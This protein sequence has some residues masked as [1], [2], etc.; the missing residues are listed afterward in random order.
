MTNL[1]CLRPVLKTSLQWALECFRNKVKGVLTINIDCSLNECV[2]TL[3]T[4]WKTE[5]E[6]QT[7]TYTHIHSERDK[8][9]ADREMERERDRELKGDG[10][11]WP[12]ISTSLMKYTYA[13]NFQPNLLCIALFGYYLSCSSNSKVASFLRQMFFNSYF[14]GKY[15]HRYQHSF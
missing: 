7:R 15:R 5:K 9:R 2:W 14:V 1:Y 3:L 6:R 8:S 10:E 13:W 12:C 4:F 11:K